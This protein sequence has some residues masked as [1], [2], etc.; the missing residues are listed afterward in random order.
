MKACRLLLGSVAVFPLFGQSGTLQG[1]VTLEAR[2]TAVHDATVRIAQLGRNAASDEQG[3]YE[4]RNVPAGSYTVLAHLHD[5]TDESRQV[6]IG[7]GATVTL[8]FRLRIAAVRT[9]VTVTATGQEQTPLEAFQTVVA[10]DSFQIT[11]RAEPSLGEMRR[12]NRG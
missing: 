1:T 10:L 4:F 12:M 8:D 7:P 11:Q 2:G 9:Q 5:F 6:Q 3:R